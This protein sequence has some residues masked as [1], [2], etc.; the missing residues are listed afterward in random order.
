MGLEILGREVGIEF[1]IEVADDRARLVEMEAIVVD[2]RH[3]TERL[4]RHVLG[5]LVFALGEIARDHFERLLGFAHR[6]QHFARTRT[7]R[8]AIELH[9]KYPCRGLVRRN[10]LIARPLGS[11]ATRTRNHPAD[12]E[13]DRAEALNMRKL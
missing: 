5:R 1:L 7:H 3:L 11:V 6:H 10:Y 12:D 2:R 8:I 13:V 4:Q 9:R